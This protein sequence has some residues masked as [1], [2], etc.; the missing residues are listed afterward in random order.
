MMKGD[1]FKKRMYSALPQIEEALLRVYEEYRDSLDQVEELRMLKGQLEHADRVLT[2]CKCLHKFNTKKKIDHLD[3][4]KAKE[5][6]KEAISKNIKLDAM[7][8]EFKNLLS[9]WGPNDL[10]A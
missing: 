5:L 3:Y 6:F 1:D 7:L 8:N 4:Q 10:L 9:Q 2:M